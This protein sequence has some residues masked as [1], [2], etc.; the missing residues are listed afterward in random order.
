MFRT[1]VI[2]FNVD[3]RSEPDLLKILFINGDERTLTILS[4]FLLSTLLL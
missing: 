4:N 2:K 3:T 1:I